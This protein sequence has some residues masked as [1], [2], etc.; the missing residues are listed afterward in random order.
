MNS[1]AAIRRKSFQ[2]GA[3]GLW[4]TLATSTDLINRPRH[5]RAGKALLDILLFTRCTAVSSPVGPLGRGIWSGM[6]RPRSVTQR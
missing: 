2:G 4:P 5:L 1:R 6:W 3:E